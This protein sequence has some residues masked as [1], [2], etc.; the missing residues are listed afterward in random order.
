MVIAVPVG[1]G[2]AIFLTELCP[3]SL[4]RA[5]R[6]RHRTA[7][8]HSLDHLRHLGPVRLRALFLRSTSSRPS[9]TTFGTFPG[10]GIL[11]AG[12]P[13]GI[14]ILTAGFILAIMVLPFISAV[15]ARRVRR[16]CRRVLKEATYG[17][18]CTTWE[19]LWRS[20][21]CPSPASA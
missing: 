18:G 16:P 15:I 19:V 2:I 4:R 7:G 12:P 6:H 8:R 17:L 20:S 1:I 11:F 5:D 14:G 13:Y 21:S 9:S 10:F 3:K